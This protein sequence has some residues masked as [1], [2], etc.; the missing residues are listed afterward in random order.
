LQVSVSKPDAQVGVIRL[1]DCR[2]FGGITWLSL[3]GGGKKTPQSVSLLAGSAIAFAHLTATEK[4]VCQF[5][6]KVFSPKMGL[7]GRFD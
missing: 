2:R 5:A 7:T 6:S 1:G 4:W 3:G